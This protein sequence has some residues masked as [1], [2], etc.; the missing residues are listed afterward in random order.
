MKRIFI[1]MNR[2][3]NKTAGTGQLQNHNR[4]SKSSR[5][6]KGY[7]VMRCLHSRNFQLYF[8]EEDEIEVAVISQR[9]VDM[10]NISVAQNCKAIMSTQAKFGNSKMAT[11]HTQQELQ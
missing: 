2:L 3:T 6:L 8:F 5:Q 4:Y 10:L 7:N 1:L 9:K 11:Q